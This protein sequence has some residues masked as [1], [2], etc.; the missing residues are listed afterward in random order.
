MIGIDENTGLIYEG[1][2]TSGH[3]IWPT[4]S[5]FRATFLE[6]D[7]DSN[8]I[9]ASSYL[10]ETTH[11]FREDSYDPVTRVRRGRIYAA[12]QDGNTQPSQWYVQ[13]HPAIFEETGR[14][15]HQGEFHKTLLTFSPFR[16]L[17]TRVARNPRMKLALGTSEAFSIWNIIAVETVVSG[18]ELVTLRTR[19]NLGVLPDVIESLLPV[20]GRQSIVSALARVS[21]AAYRSNPVAIVD[22]CRDAVQVVLSHWLVQRGLKP[23]TLEEDLGKIVK[24]ISEKFAERRA[25]IDAANLI[26][27][28]H[29]RGKS[30]EQNRLGL[31][32]PVEQDAEVA[33]NLM[34]FIVR[35][36][37]WG[38]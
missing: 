24:T 19:L 3:G 30:S 9:P 12:M 16:G 27:L 31:R 18:E 28:L 17:G 34:G 20:S 5:I 29:P 8:S 32:P 1:R 2:S 26:R 10:Y 23:E 38:H 15:N 37:G 22:Q 36:L 6:A 4:P 7:E 33:L 14:R 13:R 25:L 11:V 35:D 21:D